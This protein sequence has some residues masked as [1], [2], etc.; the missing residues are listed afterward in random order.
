MNGAPNRLLGV[1]PRPR[2]SGQERTVGATAAVVIVVVGAAA[3]DGDA[4]G[5][6]GGHHQAHDHQRRS[7]RPQL[8]TESRAT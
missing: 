1:R 3:A 2:Q 5:G 6:D 8:P 4:V 7:L